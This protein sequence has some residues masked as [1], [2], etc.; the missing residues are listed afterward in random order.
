MQFSTDLVVQI[1][2]G[3]SGFR[4]IARSPEPCPSLI[5]EA[6]FSGGPEGVSFRLTHDG[7]TRQ[8]PRDLVARHPALSA[9]LRLMGDEVDLARSPNESL[10]ALLFRSLL[11]YAARMATPVPLPRW[12]RPLRD[13]R[14]EKAIEL[15]N[16]DIAK[17]WTVELLA[18]AVGLSRPAFARQFVR[19]FRLS[20]MRYL[21]ERRLQ[22]AAHLLYTSDAGLAEVAARVGYT[23]EFA[24]SRA[25]KRRYQLPP[26]VYRRAPAN[27]FALRA[28]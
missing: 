28:A 4:V 24:F 7:E 3:R 2:R 9:V 8:F 17:R 19:I 21:T 6:V 25:F 18:R 13:R 20:P 15:L 26:G 5:V 10:L 22:L 11:V 27:V 1:D 14:I 16:E 12:G 23:S